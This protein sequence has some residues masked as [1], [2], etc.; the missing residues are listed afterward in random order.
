M[1]ATGGSRPVLVSSFLAVNPPSP[2][3]EPEQPEPPPLPINNPPSLYKEPEQPEPPP[4]PINNPPSP[5]K[6]KDDQQH[7]GP[8]A[9]GKRPV[10]LKMVSTFEM[11]KSSTGTMKW[12][13]GIGKTCTSRTTS[14]RDAKKSIS[15]MTI[16]VWKPTAKDYENVPNHYVLG[17]PLL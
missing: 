14:D 4:S 12:L 11:K 5:S 7:D 15:T 6:N 16:Q 3:K 17:R 1:Q 10:V 13:S 2:Y 9:K 8:K